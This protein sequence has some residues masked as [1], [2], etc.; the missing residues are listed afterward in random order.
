MS[1][2]EAM[3]ANDSTRVKG[4]SGLDKLDSPVVEIVNAP[5]WRNS[6]NQLM[7]AVAGRNAEVYGLFANSDGGD[8]RWEYLGLVAV[9]ANQYITA[10][11]SSKGLTIF[12][13]TSE[14]STFAFDTRSGSPLELSVPI[15]SNLGASVGRIVVQSTTQ[16]FATFNTGNIGFILRLEGF[17]WHAAGGSTL[18]AVE[19]D[20]TVNPPTLFAATDPGVFVSRDAGDTWQ[21]ASQGLPWRPHCT[22]LRFVAQAEGA[23]YLYL[24]TYGRS[25]WRAVVR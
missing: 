23:H 9:G 21:G 7:Y 2:P 3:R 6:G 13:G 24:S 25:V 12:V 14:G 10:V 4:P 17:H 20:R 22:D 19:I 11:G 8:M 5:A 16:V 18:L 1:S 15:R